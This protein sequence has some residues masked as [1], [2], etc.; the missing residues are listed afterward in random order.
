MRT[1]MHA[2]CSGASVCADATDEQFVADMQANGVEAVVLVNHINSAFRTYPA[3]TYKGKID[4]YLSRFDEVKDLAERNGIKVFLGAEVSALTDDGTHQEFI[5]LGFDREFL[6]NNE[7]VNA[8]NQKS[9][10][11]LANDNSLFMY[12]THPFRTGEKT[13][14]P[15]FM[16]GAEACNGHY[17]H[18]NFNAS[19]TEFCE[20]HGL[21]KLTGSDYH[22]HKQPISGWIELPD[23][24]QNEKQLAKYLLSNQPKTFYDEQKYLKGRQEYLQ[25]QRSKN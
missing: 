14:D 18:D 9:L 17:H 23:E 11:K 10:F 4:Y 13:G 5:L 20:K 6:Y 12:Q 21:K 25:S 15:L 1:E 2:H 22:H 8:Y 19:A 24:I 7:L 3:Q 16:H